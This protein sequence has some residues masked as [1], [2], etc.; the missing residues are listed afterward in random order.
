MKRDE[1]SITLA[2][3]TKLKNLQVIMV[4]H[5]NKDQDLYQFPTYIIVVMLLENAFCLKNEN[6][7]LVC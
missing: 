5:H 3:H 7:L 6:R 2:R 1:K 4:H